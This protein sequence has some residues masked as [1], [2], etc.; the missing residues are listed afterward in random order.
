MSQPLNQG[1]IGYTRPGP[2]GPHLVALSFKVP[3]AFRRWF[4]LQA[5][6]NNISMT[7]LL[8]LCA[9]SYAESN[10]ESQRVENTE[11]RK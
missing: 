7:E 11:I 4:K 2:S 6:K 5:L 1:P 8:M 3:F 9:E 10:G